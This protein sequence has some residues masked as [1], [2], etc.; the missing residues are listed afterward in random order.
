MFNI[1]ANKTLFS[2]RVLLVLLVLKVPVVLLV[3]L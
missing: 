1:T 2:F 3:L